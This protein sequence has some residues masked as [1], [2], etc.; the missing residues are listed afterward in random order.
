MALIIDDKLIFVHIR[1]TGGSFLRHY[2]DEAKTPTKNFGQPEDWNANQH[3][4]IS[5]LIDID[6]SVFGL[7]SFAFVREPMQWIRSYWAWAMKSEYLRKVKEGHQPAL[8]HWLHDCMDESFTIFLEKYLE[9]HKGKATQFILE[10]LGFH[11]N[12]EED[13]LT[14]KQLV[15]NVY[16]YEFLLQSLNDLFRRKHININYDLLLN[17][18]RRREAAHFKYH[19]ASK[20]PR[21]LAKMYIDSEHHVY[22]KYYDMY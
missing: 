22:E 19:Y 6:K 2:L 5:Q 10:P 7:E 11:Y 8:D 21:Q 1:K 3:K 13:K 18:P 12:K 4:S 16:K 14:G 17:T 9:L 20:I 15:T